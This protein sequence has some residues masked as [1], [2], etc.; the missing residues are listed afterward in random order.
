MT[1]VL[2]FMF[3][4]LV[5][6][7]RKIKEASIG[8][9]NVDAPMLL[10]KGR[11]YQNNITWLLQMNLFCPLTDD[12]LSSTRYTM[13]TQS[14][15]IPL[16]V[17]SNTTSLL[18][19]AST[20]DHRSSNMDHQNNIKDLRTNRME[21]RSNILDHRT[22]T[23]DQR[24][25]R[26]YTLDQREHRTSTL[27]QRSKTMDRNY[28]AKDSHSKKLSMWVF[29][30]MFAKHHFEKANHKQAACLSDPS[31]CPFIRLSTFIAECW[32]PR[33]KVQFVAHFKVICS[34]QTYL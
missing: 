20:S 19:R 1:E 16:L 34:E 22:S 9:G 7:Y 8:T 32:W 2:E 26:T 17:R 12:C 11:G 10:S 13:T 5:L 25:H 29:G 33:T 6:F 15:S 14:S 23:I 18:D 4:F 31:V 28:G 3:F 24:D 21:H 27:Y 30:K